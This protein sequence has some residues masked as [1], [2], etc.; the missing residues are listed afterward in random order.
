MIK[1]VIIGLGKDIGILSAE[2]TDSI[3]IKITK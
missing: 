3:T 2:I 1:T